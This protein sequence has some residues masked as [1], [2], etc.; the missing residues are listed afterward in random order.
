MHVE[1]GA[2]TDEG[3]VR[4]DRTVERDDSG[5][6]LDDEF[7][8][9]APRAGQR[10]LAG[11]AGD[12]QLGQHRVELAA[13][14]RAGLHAGVQPHAGAGRDVVAGDGS[15]GGQ[16][17]AAGVLA[18]DAELDRVP[19][20][21]RVLGDGQRL[22]VGDLELLQHQVDAGGLLGDGVLDLQAGVDLEEADQA[23]LADQVL[24]GA[25]A[26]VAGLLADPLGGLVDLLALRVGQERRRGLLDQLL[27]AAL[28]RAVAGACDDDV[29]VHVGDDLGFDV[30]RLVQVALDEAL[31]A[32][33]RGDGLAGGR[34]EQLGDLLDGAGHLHAAPAAAER[35][36]D[37]DGDAVLLGELDDLV[38]VLDRVGGAGHQR[39]LGAGGDVTGGDLVAEVADGLRAGPDPDQPGVEHGLG[40]VGVLAQEAVA[41]VHGVGAGLGGGVEQLLE[42]QVGLRGGLPAQRERLVGEPD[43]GCVGVG[44][45]VDRHALQ[46]GIPCCADDSDRDLSAVGDEYLGDLRAGV[47]GHSASC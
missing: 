8:Q 36:L 23:V 17:P 21:G 32:A 29:A 46:P 24:D 20:R 35:G 3:G 14:H 10:L 15:G 27:E 25:G 47:T 18:I 45:G 6:A 41:G 4:D 33:E 37:R 13:D 43:V 7:V 28:Q 19:A 26:V 42:D 5:Q 34:V 1:L 31:A 40:E 44:L 38:G 22:A 30:A 2:V 12:D 11:G 9:R 39:G 16:E